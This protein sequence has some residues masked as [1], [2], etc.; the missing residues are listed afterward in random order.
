LKLFCN[1]TTAPI[2]A[3]HNDRDHQILFAIGPNMPQRNPAGGRFLSPKVQKSRYPS[4]EVT[5]FDEIGTLVALALLSPSADKILRFPK[6]KISAAAI[7]QI[8]KIAISQ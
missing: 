6:F 7:L 3:L 5:D 4:K 2:A 1:Q 8:K